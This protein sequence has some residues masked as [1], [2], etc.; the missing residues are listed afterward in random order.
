M[1]HVGAGG[2]K[3]FAVIPAYNEEDSV[4]PVVAGL[5]GLVDGVVVVDDHSADG[6]AA[7]GA[8]AGAVIVRNVRNLGVGGA[9]KAG[10]AEAA[11]RGADV[12]MVVAGD[13][14]HDPRDLPSLIEPIAT[15]RADYVMGNRLFSEA[16][17]EGMPVLRFAGN[18]LLTAATRLITGLDFK[19]SQCGYTALTCSAWRKM[20]SRFIT[21]RWGFPNDVLVECALR[22]L[23]VVSVNVR[24][25]YNSGTSHIFLPSYSVRLAAILARG[26]LRLIG[27][28]IK[29]G[30]SMKTDS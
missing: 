1:N 4:G 9:I 5:K 28:R 19:D 6:T 10:Y 29:L 7:A 17:S 14:Q 2:R 16:S 12:M 13:G 27:H 3:I 20:D 24:C 8:A 11:R 30:W 22:G 23:R 15:G 18:R 21:D 26:S 25:I